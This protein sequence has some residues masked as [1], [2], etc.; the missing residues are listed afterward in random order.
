M[1]VA[2][3]GAGSDSAEPQSDDELALKQRAELLDGRRVGIGKRLA[4]LAFLDLA[5]RAGRLSDFRDRAALV[6]AVRD[7]GCPVSGKTAPELARVEDEYRS[8]GVTFLFVN[9]NEA[10][11][12]S[13]MQAEVAAHGFEG[14]YAPDPRGELARALRATT[15][16]EVFVL[17]RARTLVYRGAI[18]DRVGRGFELPEPRHRFLRDA[19]DQVL[20]SDRVAVPATTAPGCELAFA[21]EPVVPDARPITYHDQVARILQDNCV[22]CH[23]A[24]GAGPFALDGFKHAKSKGGM[25]RL[26]VSERLMPPWYAAD[27]GGPW[28]NERKLSEEERQTLLD[29]L[30]QG[31][32]EGD[33]LD[34]PAPREWKDGWRIGTPDLVFPIPQPFQLPAEGVVDLQQ[35]WAEELVPED[36]WVRGLQILPTNPAVVHHATCMFLPPE[37]ALPADE[38]LFRTLVPWTQYTRGLNYLTGYL[39]GREPRRYP[40]DVALFLPKGSRIRFEVH[41]TTKG[42]VEE[43]QTRL[44]LVLAPHPPAF[45]V[46]SRLLRNREILIPPNSKGLSFSAELTFPAIVSLLS[47]TPHMHLRGDA[48]QV[49]LTYP[50]G[51]AERVLELPQWDPNW[52]FAYEFREDK[53]LPTGTN[54]RITG[55]YDNTAEKEGNPDPSQ[56]V[57]DGPQIWDEMM[58]CAVEWVRPIEASN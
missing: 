31:T 48:F 11:E 13:E 36:V 51:R 25:I 44:G 22:E 30:A 27:G 19:L 1:L 26:M 49:N 45:V 32:P 41:Y 50:D 42:R 54:L 17:D 35:F 7:V 38:E 46:N 56:A 16:T 14:R 15:T 3:G 5:G 39:P 12:P 28:E 34:A 37:E 4:D 10:N 43:D 55:W 40:E 24:G 9:P 20:A 53:L 23:R 47:L 2:C 8:Q 52:Q 6:I 58:M 29:W 18:D 21:K 57:H 33:P